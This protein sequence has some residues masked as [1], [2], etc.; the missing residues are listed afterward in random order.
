MISINN[1]QFYFALFDSISITTSS[2]K[3]DILRFAFMLFSLFKN[4]NYIYIKNKMS[5]IDELY[6][7]SVRIVRVA[8]F[9]RRILI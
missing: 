8:C 3:L 1:L 9:S 4:K 5:E 7:V 2:I 6:E